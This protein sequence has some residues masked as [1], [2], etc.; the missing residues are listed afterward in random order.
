MV[1]DMIMC[2]LGIWYEGFMG[3]SVI[4]SGVMR[5]AK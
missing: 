5:C 1:A 2:N 4:D 3:S